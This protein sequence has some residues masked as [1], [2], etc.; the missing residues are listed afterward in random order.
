MDACSAAG[1]TWRKYRLGKST[2][3]VNFATFGLTYFTFQI[4]FYL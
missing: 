1:R 3:S 4:N 2:F